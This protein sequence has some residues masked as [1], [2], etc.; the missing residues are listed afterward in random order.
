MKCVFTVPSQDH[1]TMF[2]LFKEERQKKVEN[3]LLR[4]SYNILWGTQRTRP[5]SRGDNY[6]SSPYTFIQCSGE[7]SLS[8]EISRIKF[9]VILPSCYTFRWIQVLGSNSQL[10]E[11]IQLKSA[12]QSIYSQVY[13]LVGQFNDQFYESST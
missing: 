3:G 9:Y 11:R 10:P 13:F 5:F 2:L 8:H 6:L 1:E 12:N 4:L 7:D